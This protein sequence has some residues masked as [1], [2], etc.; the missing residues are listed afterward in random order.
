MV[1]HH[2][3]AIIWLIVGLLLLLPLLPATPVKAAADPTVTITVSAW[4]VGTPSGLILTYIT[5]WEIGIEWTKG[6]GANN[7]MIRGLYGAIPADRTEGYLVYYGNGTACSDT[8]V[9]LDDPP[10]EYISDNADDLDIYYRAWS[11]TPGGIWEGEGVSATIGG[12]G[13]T[14]IGLIMLGAFLMVVGFWRRNQALLWVAA[15]SWTGFAFWQQSLMA[16]WGTWDLHEIMFML[17]IMMVIVCI[18]E[19]TMINRQENE[20][21]AR[22]RELTPAERHRAMMRDVQ[23]RARIY[24]SRRR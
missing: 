4:V 12:I 21:P 16:A 14:F 1:H 11:E 7:T 6:E 8:T 5:E 18:V 3:R 2:C 15:L 19:A 13:M 22:R 24:S 20:A 17:G 23:A 9:N 10:E